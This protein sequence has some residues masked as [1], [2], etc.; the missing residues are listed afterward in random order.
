MASI[1]HLLQE[2][3]PPSYT[4]TL[5]TLSPLTRTMEHI[6]HGVIPSPHAPI[7]GPDLFEPHAEVMCEYVSVRGAELAMWQS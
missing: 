1:E 7:V 3:I 6:L 4:T 2:L 5:S